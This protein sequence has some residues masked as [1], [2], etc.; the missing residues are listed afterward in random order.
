MLGLRELHEAPPS[1]APRAFAAGKAPRISAA[2]SS[3]SFSRP[4]KYEVSGNVHALAA[5]L[6]ARRRGSRRRACRS[7][8]RTSGPSARSGW[9]PAALRSSSSG[10]RTNAGRPTM[11][12]SPPVFQIMPLNFGREL[13][14]RARCHHVKEVVVVLLHEIG[15]AVGTVQ[16]DEALR[17]EVMPPGLC[18]LRQRGRAFLFGGLQMAERRLQHIF[19][20]IERRRRGDQDGESAAPAERP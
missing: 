18:L 6:L 2:M 4:S 7:T 3:G 19:L 1:A 16:L 15:I 8:S 12:R 17:P 13:A 10:W 5:P 14:A 9:W 11:R 20:G